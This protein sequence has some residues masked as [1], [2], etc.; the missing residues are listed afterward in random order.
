M[1]GEEVIEFAQRGFFQ[2]NS[3]SNRLLVGAEGHNKNRNAKLVGPV[4]DLT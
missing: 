3:L 1:P 4:I 2:V